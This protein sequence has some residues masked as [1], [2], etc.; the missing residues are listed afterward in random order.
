MSRQNSSAKLAY[1]RNRANER[2]IDLAALERAKERERQLAD[3]M[4][5]RKIGRTMVYAVSE[6]RLNYIQHELEHPQ[7][8]CG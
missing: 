8:K 5:R 4:H 3:K 6:E 2:A 7:F 1:V